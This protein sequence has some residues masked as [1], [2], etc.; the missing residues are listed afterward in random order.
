VLTAA[1]SLL[2]IHY[3]AYWPIFS[4]QFAPAEMRNPISSRVREQFH[5]F[6]LEQR[7]RGRAMRLGPRVPSDVDRLQLS[8]A[9]EVVAWSMAKDH[10]GNREDGRAYP[11]PKGG[12]FL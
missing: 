6:A 11:D 4:A 12:L 7:R 9:R 8:I 5:F 3:L 2:A 1:S 10:C